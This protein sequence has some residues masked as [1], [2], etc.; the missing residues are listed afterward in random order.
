[1]MNFKKSTS[2]TA[3]DLTVDFIPL[4]D[5]LLVVLIFITATTSFTQFQELPIQLPSGSEQSVSTESYVLAV[6]QEG[7]YA[8]EGRLL[9]TDER[10]VFDALQALPSTD[11]LLIYADANAKHAAVVRALEAARQAHFAKISFAT[12]AP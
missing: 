11:S 9:S 12:Q 8:L 3:D 2:N 6:S 1:M 10:S 5:I 4:I 7:Q